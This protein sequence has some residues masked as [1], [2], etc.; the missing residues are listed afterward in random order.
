[1]KA[2]QT[3][4]TDHLAGKEG[5]ASRLEKALRR[6]VHGLEEQESTLGRNVR[7]L[8]AKARAMKREMAKGFATVKESLG[9][10]ELKTSLHKLA[11]SHRT[12]IDTLKNNHQAA[13]DKIL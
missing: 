2:A 12:Q 9:A 7:E 11:D 1:M 4:I 13:V 5:E 3:L 6:S 8:E 10:A